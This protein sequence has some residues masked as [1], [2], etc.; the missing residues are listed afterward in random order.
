MKFPFIAALVT[1]GLLAADV[2]AQ[3]PTEAQF[4][5]S[6]NAAIAN[7]NASTGPATHPIVISGNLT[8]AD[9]KVLAQASLT[10]LLQFV[11][12]LKAAGAQRIDLNPGVTSV[13][14][15]TT[16]ALLD[17]LVTHIRQLGLQLAINPEITPGEL[18]QRPTFDTFQAA[19]LQSYAQLA[20]RYQPENFVIIHEPTTATASLALPSITVQQWHDFITA[21]APLIKAAS[22]H[23]R[24]GAGGFQN[25]VLP[26]LSAQENAFFQDAATIPALDFLTMDL[27]N[28]DT[29][30]VYQ[31][32]I[33]LAR[34]NG[35]GIYIEETGEPKYLPVP[36]P[37]ALF[38]ANGYLTESLDSI[39]VIGPANADFAPLNAS[40]AQAMSNFAS[41]NGLEALTVFET[42]P[43]FAWGAA[44]HDKET[45]PA[46]VSA[47]ISALANG[48]LTSTG[49]AYAAITAQYGIKT[50]VSVSNASYATVP[51]AYTVGCGPAA[52]PCNASSTV[53]PDS[54]VSAFGTDLA[55]GLT[56]AGSSTYP[57][58][59]GGT[60]LTLVDSSNTSYTVPL[61]FVAP[62]QVNYLVPSGVH[63]GPAWLT[64]TSGDG[65]VSQG[66]ILVA[67]VAPGIYSAEANGQ[68]V[69]AAEVVTQ[70]ADNSQTVTQAFTCGSSA[71]A[72]QPIS[73]GQAGDTVYLELYGTGLRHASSLSAVTVQVGNLSLPAQY[74]GPQGQYP[75]L[76]QVNVRLPASL[77]GSGAVNVVVK[78]QDTGAVSNVVTVAIR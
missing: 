31:Q 66:V 24:L 7:L 65:K 3:T 39:A 77:A 44:G 19:A 47:V 72:P 51:G 55:T 48:Q 13:T 5:A 40:W 6:V 34:A 18:G 58:T 49:K 32:W 45:D 17:G 8:Y 43:L 21:A 38:S 46:Y 59:L 1:A 71:C 54:L 42:E 22:P 36:L 23:T 16:Q 15:P 41:A 28:D 33:S 64:I 57:T 37:T 56:S 67:P 76:D 26:T 60:S 12:G 27:Y 62:G 30:P 53:A 68:G 4:I 29:F 78:T 20:A 74:V 61:T 75:G 14:N 50:A 63:A 73:L 25:G 35:K 10:T 69:A 70:H 11:D 52:S 2:C 9:G